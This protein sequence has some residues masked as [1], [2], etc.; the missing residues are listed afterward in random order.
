MIAPFASVLNEWYSSCSRKQ[1]SSAAMGDL[2]F[3]KLARAASISLLT[4]FCVTK[5]STESDSKTLSMSDAP[6]SASTKSPKVM[7]L[8]R[9]IRRA[10]EWPLRD[11]HGPWLCIPVAGDA[12]HVSETLSTLAR[13]SNSQPSE[14][15]DVCRR[16]AT[17]STLTWF[18]TLPPASQENHI[19]PGLLR[20]MTNT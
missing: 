9:S 2:P 16:F 13:I 4:S 20:L 10:I 11:A 7:F 17:S 12:T 1:S 6:S 14:R 3:K 15:L 19:F 8:V 18:R 5:L